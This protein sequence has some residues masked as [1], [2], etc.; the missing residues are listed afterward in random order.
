MRRRRR[1]S[2]R[3]FFRR[4]VRAAVRLARALDAIVDG[5]L[6]SA[7]D[8]FCVQ[9]RGELRGLYVLG[10]C[11]AFVVITQIAMYAHFHIDLFSS[12]NR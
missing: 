9:R 8:P 5:G 10:A 6:H 7:S 11:V 3:E 4:L 2:I 1:Q 12:V